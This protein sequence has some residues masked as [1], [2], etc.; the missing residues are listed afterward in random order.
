MVR[1]DFSSFSTVFPSARCRCRE[2]RRLWIRLQLAF[3]WE[4]SSHWTW[5]C[6]SLPSTGTKGKPVSQQVPDFKNLVWNIA[7]RGRNRQRRKLQ[8][9]PLVFWVTPRM[10]VVYPKLLS[11]SFL[12][13]LT[14]LDEGIQFCYFKFFV[15]MKL[16][17][18]LYLH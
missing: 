17:Y 11:S 18:L 5:Q 15:R 13:Y 10:G 7:R 4:S 6:A 1:L 12:I 3:N 2:I 9:G 16:S 14:N 8:S